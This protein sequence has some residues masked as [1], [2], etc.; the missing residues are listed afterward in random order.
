MARAGFVVTVHLFL[1]LV[2]RKL[3]TLL[4]INDILQKQIFYYIYNFGNPHLLSSNQEHMHELV[5]KRKRSN[6]PFA[7]RRVPQA[8]RVRG[9]IQRVVVGRHACVRRV[10]HVRRVHGV[11][12]VCRVSYARRH[13]GGHGRAATERVMPPAAT[14]AWVAEAGFFFPAYAS[15]TSSVE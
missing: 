3:K 14:E 7:V 1:Q 12:R 4:I 8:L 15:T 2:T 13:H 9:L 5:R 11:R 10:G 6:S